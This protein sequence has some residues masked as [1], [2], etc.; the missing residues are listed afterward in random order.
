MIINKIFLG[1][2][3][4]F[5]RVTLSSIEKI[6]HEQKM[7]IA[8][9]AR[10]NKSFLRGFRIPYLDQG[11]NIHLKAL[12]KL[13]FAYDSTPLVN[14]NDTQAN[15]LLR[16]W[17]HTLDFEPGYTCT[18]CPKPNNNEPYSNVSIES[19]WSVPNH[20]LNIE[21]I[22]TCPLLINNDFFA[23]RNID[24]LCIEPKKLTTDI[25]T[26][27]LIE[28]FNRQYKTNKAPF[29][30]NIELEWFD[31]YGDLITD[32]LVQFISNITLIKN[33]WNERDIYFVSMEKL[34]EWIQ[35]PTNLKT[36]STRWLW[37]CDY[38]EYDY[39]R[40]CN[41][42]INEIKA[43]FEEL[44]EAKKRNSTLGY[45]WQTE[46]LFKNGILSGVIIAF[47]LSFAITFCYDK[48]SR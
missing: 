30:I 42:Y 48:L 43:T 26:N 4:G 2:G 20:F 15:N 24:S 18:S 38:V 21:S 27:Q 37:D 17:P 45:N 3:R 7:R 12:K 25:L 14:V 10:I 11:D 46:I 44:V 32:S 6:I 33:S 39:D 31:K 1:K 36:I 16:F 47:I 9:N 13:A 35:Y 40:D 19:F 29:I 22:N 41:E 23:F 5:N 8:M 34:I 28:N